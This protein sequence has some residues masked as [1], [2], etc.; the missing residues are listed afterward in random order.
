MPPPRL[1]RALRSQLPAITSFYGFKPWE[2]DRLTD[3]ELNEYVT[4]LAELRK[5]Q[6]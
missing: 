2:L 1:R 4:Q 5:A 6:A 3:G